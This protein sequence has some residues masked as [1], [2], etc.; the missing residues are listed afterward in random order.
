[1]FGIMMA[2]ARACWCLILVCD[3]L[4]IGGSVAVDGVCLTA[5]KF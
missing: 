1:M 4:A 2:Y 5:T 3:G